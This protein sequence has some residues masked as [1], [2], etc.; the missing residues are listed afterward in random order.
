MVKEIKMLDFEQFKTKNAELI[1]LEL[2]V[3]NQIAKE[4]GRAQITVNDL[5]KS[6]VEHT[7]LFNKQLKMANEGDADAQYIVG[8]FFTNSA[9]WDQSDPVLGFEYYEMG[10]KN[11]NKF[12]SLK[13]GLSYLDGIYGQEIDLQKAK[14]FFT[15]AKQ[16]GL[17]DADEYIKE[18]NN[19]TC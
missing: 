12:A 17:N 19:R 6:Y 1:K 14:D 13:V 4:K 11:G 9:E 5:Y 16:Q 18:A 8:N 10:S 15:L 7:K 3:K 2:N